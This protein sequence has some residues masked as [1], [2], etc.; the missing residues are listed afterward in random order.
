MKQPALTRAFMFAQKCASAVIKPRIV[1]LSEV[2]FNAEA[3]IEA[4]L[5]ELRGHADEDGESFR[6]DERLTSLEKKW[7]RYDGELI[8]A[9]IAFVAD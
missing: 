8:V 4:A 1:Y 3:K 7:R 9:V 2:H 6:S 5:S